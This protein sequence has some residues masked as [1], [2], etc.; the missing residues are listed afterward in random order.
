MPIRDQDTLGNSCSREPV[1]NAHS[2]CGVASSAQARVSRVAWY[3]FCR[4]RDDRF[5]TVP[6]A[7]SDRRAP[8]SVRKRHEALQT[9]DSLPFP[10][11][12][13]TMRVRMSTRLERSRRGAACCN[14]A[15]HVPAQGPQVMEGDR[16][17]PGRRAP[18]RSALGD[19]RW[20]A[21]EEAGGSGRSAVLG[22]TDEIDRWL[23]ASQF[24]NPKSFED[25]IATESPVEP[26]ITPTRVRARDLALVEIGCVIARGKPGDALRTTATFALTHCKAESAGFSI[27]GSDGTR[28]V[29]RWV[30][31]CGRMKPFEH[32]TT[33]A[34]FSPCGVCLEPRFRPVP[35]PGAVLC[36]LE[37]D[38]ANRGVAPHP[39]V[40]RQRG[41]RNHLDH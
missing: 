27:L 25:I 6:A 31:T 34:D 37:A 13:K 32:G 30:A 39:D 9:T 38:I 17:I 18:N 29:F 24:R 5:G 23:R 7:N 22:L 1:E 3:I 2:S 12:S 21:R 8:T 33:P 26:A 11:E 14:A 19:V 41:P 20:V 16:R 36:L 10:A 28:E 35:E 15:K 40:R 4:K